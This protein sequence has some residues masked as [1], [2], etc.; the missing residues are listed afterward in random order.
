L[1]FATDI[2]NL[3]G[4]ENVGKIFAKIF[5]QTPPAPKSWQNWQ[6]QLFPCSKALLAMGL[7]RRASLPTVAN[8]PGI[9]KLKTQMA[10][11]SRV[12]ASQRNATH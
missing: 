9:G 5:A 7:R 6:T 12:R 8:S 3:V 11:V 4:V 1:S 2:R 10:T